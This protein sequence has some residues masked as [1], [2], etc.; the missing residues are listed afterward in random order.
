MAKRREP[1]TSSVTAV[2]EIVGRATGEAAAAV[3][4]FRS[5]H[6]DPIAEIAEAIPTSQE[7]LTDL[8]A[9][10][11]LGSAAVVAKTRDVAHRAQAVVRRARKRAVKRLAR[12][13][14]PLKA[15]NTR[16]RTAPAPAGSK[17]AASRKKRRTK[18]PNPAASGSADSAKSRSLQTAHVKRR[19]AHTASRG[20]RQQA[21]RDRRR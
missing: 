15:A 9:Q 21:R 12:A 13:R 11:R 20:R 3:E 6:H 10:A 18:R 16:G 1:S 17:T 8:T 4:A 2:A 5:R 7:A 19:Q 14:K